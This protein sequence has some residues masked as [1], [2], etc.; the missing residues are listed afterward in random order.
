MQYKLQ[1]TGAPQRKGNLQSTSQ[2]RRIRWVNGIQLQLHFFNI[3]FTQ[4]I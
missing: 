3:L 1:I 2:T 4:M